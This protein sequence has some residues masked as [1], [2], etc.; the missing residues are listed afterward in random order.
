MPASTPGDRRP[1]LLVDAPIE[2]LA[3]LNEWFATVFGALEKIDATQVPRRL[4]ELGDA[5]EELIERPRFVL[6]GQVVQAE[7]AHADN[8]DLQLDV[9]IEAAT[10][11]A[12]MM[13]I[14]DE[15]DEWCRSG[16]LA[17][18]PRT[19]DQV[20]VLR[21]IGREIIGQIEIGRQPRPFRP[22]SA[23]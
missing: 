6:G 22:R 23:D 9:G 20:W 14:L 5:L 16:H 12:R 8:A 10:R 2:V 7:A 18:P 21:W 1:V 19:A 15:L 11:I 13:L 3:D 17:A 4:V